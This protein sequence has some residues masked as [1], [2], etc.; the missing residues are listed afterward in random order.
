M[1]VEL[2]ENANQLA[3]KE[4]FQMERMENVSNN[5]YLVLGMKV[6]IGV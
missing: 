3:I 5:V 6:L 1:Q 4:N 2:Q